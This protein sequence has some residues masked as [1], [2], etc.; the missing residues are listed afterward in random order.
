MPITPNE[1]NEL[2][3]LC[4]TE[5]R[6]NKA[7]LQIINEFQKDYKSDQAIWWY[8]RDSFLY[9]ML[10]KALRIQ[11]IDL[12]LLFRYVIHDIQ[13][14]LE[15]NKFLSSICVYRGQLMSKD[16]LQMLKDSFKAFISINSFISAIHDR[17]SALWFLFDLKVSSDIERVLFEI[18]ADEDL[19]DVKAFNIIKSESYYNQEEIFFS[20]GSIFQLID[21]HLGE[22][23]IW[24]IQMKLCTNNHKQL[25]PIFEHIESEYGN[26]KTSLLSFGLVAQKMN[27][28]DEA[29]KYYRRLIKLLP[30]QHKDA[31][32]CQD[33]ITTITIKKEIYKKKIESMGKSVY[34][35]MEISKTNDRGVAFT[36]SLGGETYRSNGDLARALESYE[37]AISIWKTFS[38]GDQE[39]GRCYYNMGLIYQEKNEYEKALEY[40]EK[41][42]II[43]KRYL[44]PDHKDLCAICVKI[45]ELEKLL[46]IS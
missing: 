21:I 11:N 38:D 35:Y 3:T 31:S 6:G 23:N 25:Q 28:F 9:K 1:K 34:N 18:H 42:Q 22:E 10:N 33:A 29:E 44:L 39:Q 14:Q 41:A 27:K 17:K 32:K 45:E 16:E 15:K 30:A 13:Y 37:K 40:Y 7:E 2:I 4:K 8:T 43:L 20:I 46:E 12:L 5:Y 36:H 19:N 26:A 24:I